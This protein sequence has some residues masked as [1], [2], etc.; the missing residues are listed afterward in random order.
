MFSILFC[1]FDKKEYCTVSPLFLDVGRAGGKKLGIGR[2]FK[3]S[4]TFLS[5]RLAD[6]YGTADGTFWRYMLGTSLFGL[7]SGLGGGGGVV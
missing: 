7:V 5:W 6:I 1:L 3:F 4:L 2:L